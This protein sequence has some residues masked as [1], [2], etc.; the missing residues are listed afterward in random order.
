MSDAEL[1]DTYRPRLFG[2]AY[3]MLGS[4]MDAEDIVQ[5]AYL[6]W[7]KAS[8]ATVEAPLGYLTT[9]VTRLC[10]DHLR[11]AQARREHYIGPWL[12]EPLVAT[13]SD[14]DATA[15][16]DESLSMALLVLLETLT[17]VERAVF[18]LREVF[19]YGYADIA[20]IVGKS[21][22]SCRQLGTRARRHVDERKPRFAATPAEHE[23]LLRRFVQACTAGE[24]AQL[25]ALLSQ[26]VTLWSDGGGK[27][28]AALNPIHGADRVSR[29][30]LGILAKAPPSLALD[31]A[32]V[33]GRTGVILRID[34]HVSH[35]VSI[36]AVAGQITALHIMANPDKLARL[37]VRWRD[38]SVGESSK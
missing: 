29:F 35:V 11:S 30:L 17:P 13:P 28:N 38:V 37:D 10:I 20:P 21:E 18:L 1:F 27:V 32:P 2:L 36:D 8:G 26:E 16:L 31:Y 14:V 3:R 25:T 24:M 23:R 19:G 22:V 15:F 6:R 34:G 12:P 9:V 5:E 4:A 7:Q 33:N